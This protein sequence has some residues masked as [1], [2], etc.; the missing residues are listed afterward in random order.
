M[1]HKGEKRKY[2]VTN[3]SSYNNS[4][5]QRGSLSIVFTKDFVDQWYSSD[6]RKGRGRPFKYS[7]LC[8]R[9]LLEIRY[10]FKLQYRQLVGFVTSLFEKM[11][12]NLEV[13]DYTQICRRS[14]QLKL[15]S[16]RKGLSNSGKAKSGKVLVFDA[17]GLKIYGEGEWK[18]KKHGKERGR[19][20]KELIITLDLK[21]RDII[22]CELTYPG[23]SE[24]EYAERVLRDLHEEGVEVDS[25]FGD[26]SYDTIKLSYYC[27][28]HNIQCG[29]PP[30]KNAVLTEEK[31]RNVHESICSR[32]DRIK[33]IRKY[34]VDEWKKVS[35]YHQ[36]S[37]VENAIYRYKKI[38]SDRLSSRNSKNML[39][40][41][42]TRWSLINKFNKFSLP[43]TTVV[44]A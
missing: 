29:V 28:A 26:G 14:A 25:I 42:Y 32:D 4:L 44:E 15:P 9:I 12:L 16:L 18:V 13:P 7:D 17:T 22:D 21:S 41:V 37:L 20:W 8:I 5:Q 6:V 38:F 33:F 1:S 2:K 30:N 31:Y 43:K 39:M 35:G 40:E 34:G 3:W 27:D 10:L 19:I 24:P 11:D 23:A 36:R